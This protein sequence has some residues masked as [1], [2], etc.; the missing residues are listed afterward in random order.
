MHMHKREP[1]VKLETTL[2]FIH[3]GMYAKVGNESSFGTDWISGVLGQVQGTGKGPPS[4]LGLPIL[5]SVF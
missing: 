5:V 2:S 1:K 3:T 4:H